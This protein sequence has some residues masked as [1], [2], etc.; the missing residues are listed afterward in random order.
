MDRHVAVFAFPFA[1]H[2]ALILTLVR[3]LASA[4]PS[5]VFSFFNTKSSNQALFAK[6]GCDNIKPYDVSDGKPE[7]Y[8]FGGNPDEGINLFLA[9]AEE[10]FRRGV[11]V[12]EMDIG[13][14][15]SCLVVDAFLGFSG[16]IAQDMNIPWVGFWPSGTCSLAAHFYTDLIREKTA[17]LIGSAGPDEEIVDLI[18]GLKSV[19][20]GDLPSGIILGNL[21][22]PFATMLHKMGRSLAKATA[23]PINSFQE[24][25]PDLT[26]HLSSK[27][28]N[29][30][31]IGP[32]NLISKENTPN[33][34]DEFSCISWL[35]NHK[36][37]AVA[38]ICFGT[39]FKLPPQELVALAETLEETNT[40]FLWSMNKDSYN[41]FPKG[42]MDRT[43]A[44]GT[45]KVV[46]WAPQDQV[47]N[48]DAIGV[49]VT[50]GGYNS[51]MESIGAGVPMICRPHIGDHHINTWMIERV[52]G[53]GLRIQ[54]G[55]FT[56]HATRCA[57][58]RVISLPK[59]VDEKNKTLKDLAHKAVA[60]NAS[61]DQNFKTL[62]EVINVK[63]F[64]GVMVEEDEELQGSMRLFLVKLYQSE[65]L[66]KSLSKVFT[67]PFASH[68]PLL[69]TLTRR[70][71]SAAPNVVFS[72][73]NIEKSNNV[74]F[75]NLS[76]N[77]ILR[78][79]VSDGIPEGYVFKG[80]PQ[81]D[82]NL[83]LAV[84]EEEFRKGVRVAETDTGLKIS[85]LVVDAFFWFCGDMAEEMNI[86]WVAFWTA[87]ACSLAAHV[88][89]DLIREKSAQLIGSLGPNEEIVDLIPGLKAIRLG[90][91]PSG[92][93]LGNLESPFSTMLHNMGRTL[94][95]ATAVPLNSFQELDPDL[96]EN[97]SLKLNKFLNIGP[98]NLTSKEKT[99]LQFDEF[100]CISWLDNQKTKTVA[101]ICFGTIFTPPPNELVE[102]AKA[103]E[104]TETPF[105]WSIKKDATK[106][107]PN[108][109]L[110]K[111]TTNGIGKVVAWAPQDQVLNHDAIGVFVTH[112]GWNSVLESVGAG[113]PMICRPFLG[114]QHINSWMV[115]RVWGIGSIIEGGSFTK[116]A[117]CC[118]LE[119]VLSLSKIR[120]ERIQALK[121]LAHNAVEPN[122]SSHQNFKTLV[123][124]VTGA[125][126]HT[127][128]NF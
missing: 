73:F 99:A 109:F 70:L 116:R 126:R 2:P 18:P 46:P 117:T 120:H 64:N 12:A 21:E 104:E 27:L 106:H 78:Y 110:D 127:K 53:I 113:V 122:G 103:L 14:Q 105:L 66:S 8:V 15:V 81:E 4:A 40:P 11:R 82:V 35:D 58:E 50:H 95:R 30:L 24:L 124:V 67:F 36:T 39:F 68:P 118:A 16:D 44:N 47:L 17:Q 71:A 85:C 7:D 119:Q 43:S 32:F 3:R 69:L 25:D 49:L 65:C 41:H 59:S 60:P 77:N 62:V 52:W 57:L 87:G 111:I 55:I 94:H 86:P 10:E 5:V 29:F 96:T 1:S 63:R 22:S 90:D 89:T 9:V 80:T 92:I 54:G 128:S 45:G 74:L 75:S 98:F 13:L 125:T 108:G 26:K 56:K 121:D 112:C 107:F 93:V 20:L 84:A 42:F 37:R 88:Y 115:E 23:V 19:R 34:I 72:F 33:K 79:D 83:F 102:L 91:L 51:M 61:S 101:Y 48:H 28:N 76:C 38:Y 6:P 114:D 97:L 100:S 123:E 31:N